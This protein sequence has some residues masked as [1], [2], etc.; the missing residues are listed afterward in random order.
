MSTSD[1]AGFKLKFVERNHHP[2]CI[3]TTQLLKGAIIDPS[4]KADTSIMI[5]KSKCNFILI[6]INE[7]YFL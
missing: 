1:I 5:G 2:S 4:V 3:P 7:Y 6:L